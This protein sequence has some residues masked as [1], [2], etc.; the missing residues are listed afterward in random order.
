MDA[1]A[2][3]HREN[4]MNRHNF[5]L[6]AMSRKAPEID[7]LQIMFHSAN[8]MTREKAIGVAKDLCLNCCR[9]HQE[10]AGQSEISK[11]TEGDL[12][13]L[14]WWVD[15]ALSGN[16]FEVEAGSLIYSILQRWK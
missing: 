13:Q 10:I 14:A 9:L 8:D 16:S 4:E 11:E 5:E 12:R 2:K 7:Q 15:S 1:I 6:A 3:R